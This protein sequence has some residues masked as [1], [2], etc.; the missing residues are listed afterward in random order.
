MLEVKK[1]NSANSIIEATVENQTFEEKKERIA[2]SIAKKV[3]IQGFRPGKVPIKLV[4]KIYAADIEQDA[5]SETIREVL[6]EGVKESGIKDIISEPEVTKFDKK[7][8]K[9][10]VEIKVYTKPEIEVD[11][12]YR[13]CVPNVEIPEVTEEEVEEEIKKI[14]EA[15]SETKVSQEET[16]KEGFIGIIDFTGYIDGEKME[17]GSAEAYPLEIGS[18]SFIEG[19]EEQLVGMKVEDNKRIKVTFPE[20]YSVKEIAGKEAEFDVTLQEIREKV[21]AEIND[22]FAKKYLAK[23]D[24]TLDE[25]KN[26]IKETIQNRKKAEIFAPKKEEILEC[27]VKK[28]E[29]DLP[30][31]VVEKEVEI[32]INNE[33]SKMSPAEL[34]E[35]QENLEKVKELKEKLLPEAKDR[36]KLTFIIDAIAKKEGIEVSDQELTQI[37]YYEAIMQGQNPQDVIKYYQENNLL[38]VIKMNLIEEKLLNKLLEDK[39]KGN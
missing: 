27:L 29:I 33:A 13:E 31:S 15:Q 35:L 21:P 12:E 4:K 8:D 34:K 11:D 20:N 36:V 19:F 32:M 38:P 24:A 25:L 6:N 14:A 3:K 5:I 16:L 2:K 37:L 23:E 1:L 18:S 7:D 26:M 22:E 39:V 28:Y 17:N 9:I 10:E 30:D